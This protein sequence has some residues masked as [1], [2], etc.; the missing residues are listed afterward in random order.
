VTNWH[1]GGGPA[2]WLQQA[3]RAM[4]GVN[5]HGPEQATTW[6]SGA[7]AGGA[8]RPSGHTLALLHYH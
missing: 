8:V 3:R 1:G 7:Q 2:R 5:P 4:V 6:A